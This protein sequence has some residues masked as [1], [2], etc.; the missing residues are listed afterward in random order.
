MSS[1]GSTSLAS[2]SGS[3][4]SRRLSSR[5][6]CARPPKD[7]R[8]AFLRSFARSAVAMTSST[9]PSSFA[10]ADAPLSPASI[11]GRARLRSDCW[12]SLRADVMSS[13]SPSFSSVSFRMASMWNS[14]ISLS[15][16]R[17]SL[18]SLICF[19][20]MSS[21]AFSTTCSITLPM[22]WP[23]MSLPLAA[24]ATVRSFTT[25]FM[26]GSSP[27]NLSCASMRVS[28]GTG[29]TA[30]S[31]WRFLR[32]ERVK[33]LSILSA[34]TCERSGRSAGNDPGG[35]RAGGCASM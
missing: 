35:R 20:A 7:S 28:R 12:T 15:L 6:S 33:G 3:T 26:A 32:V 10:T 19:H 29:T 17:R 18:P 24:I 34:C 22:K 14:I 11:A 2:S 23:V 16:S 21:D 27:V 8:R 31:D 9:T 25:S 1:S 13:S 30:T 4:S 5:S